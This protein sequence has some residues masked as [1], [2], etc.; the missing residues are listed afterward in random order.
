MRDGKLQTKPAGRIRKVYIIIGQK[1]MT[2]SLTQLGNLPARRID[3][4]ERNRNCF[5][6]DSEPRKLLIFLSRWLA[7][8]ETGP[9][10]LTNIGRNVLEPQLM[11]MAFKLQRL[12]VLETF[13]RAFLRCIAA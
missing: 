8:T 4:P 3:S 6:A 7:L 5:L 12:L 2:Q 11:S 1:V 10:W 13:L 9:Y